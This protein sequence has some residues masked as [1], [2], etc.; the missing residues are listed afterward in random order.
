MNNFEVFSTTELKDYLQGPDDIIN[1][2]QKLALAPVDY[3]LEEMVNRKILINYDEVRIFLY[4]DEFADG[5]NFSYIDTLIQDELS[6][7]LTPNSIVLINW[8]N[9][10]N[11]EDT[12]F[13][14]INIGNRLGYQLLEMDDDDSRLLFVHVGTSMANMLYTFY[15]D[16]LDH[17]SVEEEEDVDCYYDYYVSYQIKEKFIDLGNERPKE[18]KNLIV[19]TKD[20]I[21]DAASISSIIDQIALLNKVDSSDIFLYGFSYLGIKEQSEEEKIQDEAPSA[22][23]QAAIANPFGKMFLYEIYY[24]QN[25]ETKDYRVNTQVDLTTEEAE[26]FGLVESLIRSLETVQDD[27]EIEILD[28]VELGSGELF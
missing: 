8:Y 2:E 9:V 4:N 26:K 18:D 24:K 19:R 21:I 10:E 6:G 5:A 23:L 15:L 1:A 17:K 11:N 12:V 28:V 3:L 22:E 20:P 7:K 27:D 13:D 25:G 14:F 16:Y